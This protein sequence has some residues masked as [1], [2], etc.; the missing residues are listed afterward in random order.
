[1]LDTC[2]LVI[3]SIMIRTEDDTLCSTI[4]RRRDCAEPLLSSSILFL[5]LATVFRHSARISRVL[6]YPDA[7]LDL[8]SMCFHLMYLYEPSRFSAR[9]FD[10]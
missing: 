10:E 7:Q 4:I 8:L 3:M 6:A 5:S 9:V 2:M 1:M